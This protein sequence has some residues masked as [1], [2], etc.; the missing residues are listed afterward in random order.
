MITKAKENGATTGVEIV[1]PR[2]G[3]PEVLRVH[4]REL[5]GLAS[6]QVVVR[7]EAAGVSFAEVQMLKGRYFAQ[8]KFSFVPGYDLV[9]TVEEVG[10]DV[11]GGLAGRRVAALTQTGAW[12]ERVPLDAE[13]LA[14]VPEGLDPAEA[15]ATVTNG[16]TAWQMLHRAAKV[17]PG[18]KAK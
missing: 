3:G 14:P 7:V 5:P 16:V 15:V 4:R 6:G 1:M 12:A 10:G 8:P 9:G 2:E 13:K 11:D 18:Q 17:R